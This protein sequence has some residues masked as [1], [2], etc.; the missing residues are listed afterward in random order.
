VPA[1]RDKYG[2]QLLQEFT[3]RWDLFKIMNKWMSQFLRY[4]DRFHIVQNNLPTLNLS[5]L[6]N[7]RTT[8]FEPFQTAVTEAALSLIDDERQGESV[9]VGLL[10]K[11]VEVYKVLNAYVDSFEAPFLR[12]S[13]G[14]FSKRSQNWLAVDSTP[15][16]LLKVEQLIESE[17]ARVHAYLLPPTEAVRCF[18]LLLLVV[19]VCTPHVG[20]TRA[21]QT[22]NRGAVRRRAAEGAGDGTIGEGRLG[23]PRAVAR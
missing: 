8:V 15:Q 14:F 13:K 3:K 4:L 21:R 16:Y 11:V 17:R 22:A 9:D 23:L 6:T 19:V 18:L 2:A 20:L 12:E 5:G 10:S 1:L 7:F